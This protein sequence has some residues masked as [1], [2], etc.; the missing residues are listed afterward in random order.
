MSDSNNNSNARN[1]SRPWDDDIVIV[2]GQLLFAL[3]PESDDGRNSDN[4]QDSN[5]VIETSASLPAPT[6]MASNAHGVDTESVSDSELEYLIEEAPPVNPNYEL[7]PQVAGGDANPPEGAEAAATEQANDSGLDLRPVPASIDL[8]RNRR[9]TTWRD[10]Y[11]YV[12][13]Q[14]RPAPGVQRLCAGQPPNH[15]PLFWDEE[16]GVY[17]FVPNDTDSDDEP[18]LPPLAMVP[19]RG[20]SVSDLSQCSSD[21]EPVK[22]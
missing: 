10:Y 18:T 9:Q 11:T 2:E 6:D 20:N 5:N 13:D 8:T 21:E 15:V 14:N 17:V 4:E 7:P 12:R 3:G 16:Y 1:V 22:K 19:R